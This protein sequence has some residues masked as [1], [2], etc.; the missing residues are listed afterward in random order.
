MS[1]CVA[2]ADRSG[3][4]ERCAGGPGEQGF[5]LDE[6]ELLELRNEVRRLRGERGSVWDRAIER[7]AELVDAAVI[8]PGLAMAIRALKGVPP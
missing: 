1:G 8:V 4:C 5:T 6:K 3:G 7:A 2:C